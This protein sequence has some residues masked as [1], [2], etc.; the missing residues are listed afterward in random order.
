MKKILMTTLR[1]RETNMAAFRHAAGQMAEILAAEVADFASFLGTA[2]GSPQF[3]FFTAG[4]L[5]IEPFLETTTLDWERAVYDTIMLDNA[6]A[7]AKRFAGQ[8]D[9]T[10][11]IVV[12]DHAHPVSIIGTY[13]DDAIDGSGDQNAEQCVALG[14][15]GDHAYT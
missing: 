6:V 11:I 13:D 7:V 9:D 1:N 5:T 8:R 4:I 15:F 2:V 14:Y 3:L 10:L 12:A